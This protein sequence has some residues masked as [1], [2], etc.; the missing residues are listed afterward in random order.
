[1]NLAFLKRRMDAFTLIELLVVSAIIAILA[2]LLL[3][4]LAAA[5]E[6]ARRTACMNNLKQ[7][8]IG[9][10]SYTSDYGGYFPSCSGYG[11]SP[12]ARVSQGAGGVPS[13]INTVTFQDPKNGARQIYASLMRSGTEDGPVQVNNRTIAYGADKVYNATI[14]KGKLSMAP[15]G[16]GYLL[17]GNYAGD[18][19]TLFCPTSGDGVPCLNY[20]VDNPT[21]MAAQFAISRLSEY[22][23]GGG[24]DKDSVFSGDWAWWGPNTGTGTSPY[25]VNS[26]VVAGGLQ[27]ARAAASDYIYR[28]L[29]VLTHNAVY[30]QS[31]TLYY[32]TAVALKYTKPLAK[33]SPGS[34]AF[35]T[36]KQLGNRAIVADTFS[37]TSKLPVSATGCG[38]VAGTAKYVHKDGYNVLYGDW[39]AKWYG[40]ADQKIMWWDCSFDYGTTSFWAEGGPHLMY[41]TL[42]QTSGG[43]GTFKLGGNTG[44]DR[45]SH[46]IWHEFDIDNQIDV[47]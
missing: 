39:S 11:I 8:A 6:K 3:P 12:T 22:K 24:F 32:T 47:P 36:S 21:I 34:P 5:R 37:N 46:A 19:R 1:M 31:T 27:T 14:T 10:E 13:S 18:V 45:S 38:F 30:S 23:K 44:T 2:A 40:D 29:P 9:L 15:M 25:F 43:V 7:I 4:A 35:K 16:L 42:A 41:T 28:G 17:W 33:V 20:G 26:S